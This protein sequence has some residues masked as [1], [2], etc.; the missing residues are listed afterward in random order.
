MG[1]VAGLAL[2][3]AAGCS[4]SGP[5]K[6]ATAIAGSTNP[7]A[8]NSTPAA[9]TTATTP[10]TNAP[11]AAT[12]TTVPLLGAGQEAGSGAIPWSEVGPG[13]IL[14]LWSTRG[15]GAT[16]TTTTTPAASSD[17]GLA[18]T[19]FLVDPAGGRY[20]VMSSAELGSGYLA[21]W[22]GDGRQ[23]L[24]QLSQLTAP[25]T[26]DYEL[27]DL[28]SGS[29]R[30]LA[31]PAGSGR[32]DFTRPSGQAILD[33]AA[34]TPGTPPSS[35]GAVGRYDL[36][37]TL[38]LNYPLSYPGAG[39]TTGDFL[40]SPDGTSLLL[41][42]TVG[43]ELV[44]NDGTP[45]RSIPVPAA[46][47]SCHPTRWW[48]DTVALASCTNDAPARLW[49]VPT[50]GSVPTALTTS[51][52]TYYADNGDLDAWL[53]TTGTYVQDVLGCGV[54][55]VAKLALGATTTTQL[56]VP[57]LD[58]ANSIYVVG[59]DGDR[60]AVT[61]SYPCAGGPVLAWWDTR[62]D[63]TTLLLGGPVN[64]GSVDSALLFGQNRS[65]A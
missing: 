11:P 27:L 8:A 58:N 16:V 60:L 5:P 23:A 22:S 56:T 65:N 46:A 42:T 38:Q 48:T 30:P 50:D 18:P 55:G 7:G 6:S 14:A 39:T 32:V 47:G 37:G 4:A 64:A 13:W 3:V 26:N 31:L 59:A 36:A 9:A 53:L 10:A 1:R 54:E 20:R 43:F 29:I 49:L 2:L 51:G 57:G 45:I 21:A 63:S 52:G 24:L 25:G 61:G 12:T 35:Y 62:A 28:S 17:A 34:V 33:G 41:T 19:L 15:P 44:G 40:D